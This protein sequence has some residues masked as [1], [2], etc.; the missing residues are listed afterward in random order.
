MVVC[1]ILRAD[2]CLILYKAQGTNSLWCVS[3]LGLGSGVGLGWLRL[4]V[5]LMLQVMIRPKAKLTVRRTPNAD[6]RFKP[7][8]KPPTK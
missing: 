6:P 5:G 4:A 8:F 7:R 1:V 2:D 3:E